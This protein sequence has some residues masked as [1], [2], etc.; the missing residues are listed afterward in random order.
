LE[1][2]PANKPSRHMMKK[3]AIA[4]GAVCRTYDVSFEDLVAVNRH[5][6]LVWPRWVLVTILTDKAGMHPVDVASVM[7][8]CISAVSHMRISCKRELQ[9]NRKCR[10]TYEQLERELTPKLNPAMALY[11]EHGVSTRPTNN[12]T[13]NTK[14]QNEDH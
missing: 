5:W 4:A 3:L 10:E 11:P 1:R 13:N 2:T 6:R 14:D 7:E 12:K 8:R 9:N